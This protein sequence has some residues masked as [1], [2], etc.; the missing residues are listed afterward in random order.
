MAAH[1]RPQREVDIHANVHRDGLVREIGTTIYVC[2]MGG[3]GGVKLYQRTW[4]RALTIAG[5]ASEGGDRA[6]IVGIVECD[7]PMLD[8]EF[9]ALDYTC[10][11]TC[12]CM[13]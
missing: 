9:R 13:Q 6:D 10:T 8:L 12:T 2:C 11:H 5:I 1:A 7:R 4:P 3:G